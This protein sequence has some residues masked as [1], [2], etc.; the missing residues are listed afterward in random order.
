MARRWAS[1]STATVA[2]VPGAA[3]AS[4]PGSQYGR[5]STASPVRT[6][7]P[8]QYGHTVVAD[9]ED[10]GDQLLK[11]GIGHTAPGAL[12]HRHLLLGRA[13]P[14]VAAARRLFDFLG[15]AALGQAVKVPND[16]ERMLGERV[17]LSISASEGP[18]GGG[19]G[20]SRMTPA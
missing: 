3:G 4:F 2:P 13:G 14:A 18:C 12:P 7:R 16:S 17:H 8:A 20:D 19:N 9:A 5:P 15:E 6:V 11:P 1:L 10:V